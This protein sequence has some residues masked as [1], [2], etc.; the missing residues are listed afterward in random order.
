MRF[1]DAVE[2][3]ALDPTPAHLADL[4]ST[5]MEAPGY[6]PRVV[7]SPAAKPL[8]DRGDYEDAV[9]LLA[10]LMPGAFLSPSAHAL[11][12]VAHNALGNTDD[13]RREQHFSRMA[14]TA[15]RTSGDGT[16]ERPYTVLHVEDE[17]DVLT[18]LGAQ[19][20]SQVLERTRDGANDV[21]AL[22]DGSSVH[23]R[24]AWVSADDIGGAA[25]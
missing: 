12:F 6:D 9:E 18:A 24:L 17:Y 13:A 15:I 19:S 16:A 22:A 8:I 10:G 25:R 11:L 7:I 1:V 2:T 5:I 20:I 21:H 14:M 4:Q 23:F 3:Y